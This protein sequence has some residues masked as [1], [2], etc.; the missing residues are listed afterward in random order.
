MRL[1]HDRGIDMTGI[2]LYNVDVNNG[3]WTDIYATSFT[4]LTVNP[5][6]SSS[7]YVEI[8]LRNIHATQTLYLML[9]YNSGEA[10]TAGI[11][12]GPGETLNLEALLLADN[13]NAINTI[14]LQGSGANTTGTLICGFQLG[15]Y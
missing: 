1:N 14:S 4:T 8:S 13:G 9:R 12:V 10:V 5:L 7:N 11:P 3:A 2:G 15:A 6:D